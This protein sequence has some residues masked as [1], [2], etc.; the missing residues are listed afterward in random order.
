MTDVT[1][2]LQAHGIR[3]SLQRIAIMKY[4]LEHATHPTVDTIYQDLLPEMP[5]LSRTTVYNTLELF[6]ERGAVKVLTIDSKNVHYDGCTAAHAHFLCSS[7]GKIY[8]ITLP[9]ELDKAITSLPEHRVAQAEVYYE[10]ICR[11]CEQKEKK[12][13]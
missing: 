2:H 4:L 13:N 7:C 6:K 3:P 12:Q 8:D 5:T 10:G 1:R 11:E 9:E